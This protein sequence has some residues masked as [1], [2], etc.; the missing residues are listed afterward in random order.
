M[1]GERLEALGDR[2]GEG[3][4]SVDTILILCIN[5]VQNQNNL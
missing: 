1:E 5:D 4:S 2:G 3:I